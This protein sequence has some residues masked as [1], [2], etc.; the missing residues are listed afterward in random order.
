MPDDTF[1]QEIFQK[2][3]GKASSAVKIAFL[4]DIDSLFLNSIYSFSI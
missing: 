4:K 3:Q 2:K 1:L